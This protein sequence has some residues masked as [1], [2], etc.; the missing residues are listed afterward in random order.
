MDTGD[1]DRIY[2]YI[3]IYIYIYIYVASIFRYAPLG[4]GVEEKA[5]RDTVAMALKE[6]DFGGTWPVNH[7]L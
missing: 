6:F 5:M 2:L 7:K 1:H 3:Y 4:N